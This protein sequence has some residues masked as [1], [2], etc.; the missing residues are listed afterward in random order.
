ATWATIAAGAVDFQ[1]VVATSAS[2]AWL[3]STYPYVVQRT[4]DGGA[5]WSA[6][7]TGTETALTAIS[8]ASSTEL[9]TVGSSESVLTSADAGSTWRTVHTGLPWLRDV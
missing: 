3:L 9:W 2:Q 4:T 1:G 5:S 7:T 6:G 8:A